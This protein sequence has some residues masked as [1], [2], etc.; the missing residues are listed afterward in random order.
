MRDKVKTR[1]R[2]RRERRWK[3]EEGKSEKLKCDAGETK[4]EVRRG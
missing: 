1:K 4:N 2:E 3:E